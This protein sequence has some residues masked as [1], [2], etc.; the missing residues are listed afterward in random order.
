M[1]KP[2]NQSVGQSACRPVGQF[3]QFSQYA[4]VAATQGV[5]QTSRV[6]LLCAGTDAADAFTFLR[7]RGPHSTVSYCSS[8]APVRP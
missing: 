5:R 6:L 3:S 7:Y 2:V 8:Y 1:R 4:R